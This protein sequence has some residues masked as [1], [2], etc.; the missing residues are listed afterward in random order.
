MM[1]EKVMSAM[2]TQIN[3]EFYAAYLY[4]SMSA[5]YESLNLEG[6]A[7][8]MREQAKEEIEH[9]MKFYDFIFTRGGNVKLLQIDQPNKKWNDILGPFKDAYEHEMQ[10]T[11]W[12]HEIAKIVYDEKDYASN[13]LIQW[14]IDEQIEEEEQTSKIVEKLKLIG[15]DKMALMMLDKQLGTREEE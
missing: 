2:N 4:L 11:T 13:S 9:A 12:I 14:F 1:N 7:H 6:F 15:N 10:V 5:Y 3:R 8:W